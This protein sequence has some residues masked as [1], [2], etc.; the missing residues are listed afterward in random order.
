VTP[1][2][3]SPLATVESYVRKLQQLFSSG[4][5]TAETSYY[6]PLTQ[7]L[8]AVGSTLRPQRFAVSQ[9]ASHGAGLPDYGVFEEGGGR[10]Q[11]A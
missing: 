3:V 7:L 5:A 6:P 4:G 8:D 1:E 10:V 9:L 11:P 2:D